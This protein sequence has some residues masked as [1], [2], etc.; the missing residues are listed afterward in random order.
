VQQCVPLQ[1]ECGGPGRRTQACCHGACESQFGG[2]VMKCVTKP[3]R[4]TGCYE[5][6][7]AI[8]VWVVGDNPSRCYDSKRQCDH[9][10]RRL[11]GASVEQN[12][13][14]ESEASPVTCNPDPHCSWERNRCH[15][16]YNGGC[17]YEAACK[18]GGDGTVD[19]L[20]NG[21]DAGAHDAAV[22]SL[23]E[24]SDTGA[25]ESHEDSAELNSTGAMEALAS[26]WCA[27]VGGVCRGK[28]LPWQKKCCGS[29]KCQKLLG[30]DGTYKCVEEHPVQQC[31]P[32]H[33]ECGGPG[34]RTETCCHGT[35]ENQ[36]GGG[37]MKCVDKQCVAPHAECGG[38][39]RQTL[40]CCSPEFS[41]KAPFGSAVM[42]CM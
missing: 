22:Q 36:L 31:V 33:G 40:R 20:S 17:A 14:L 34:R 32:N 4:P 11:G 6:N 5:Y 35:C 41:C 42:K 13:T 19:G 29:A 9:Q 10:H 38:P 39:G 18:C 27:P 30:G 3:Q 8:C 25:H 1:G 16:C 24:G 21:S 15:C 37:V 7:G 12:R 26:L 2:S 23:S 28:W